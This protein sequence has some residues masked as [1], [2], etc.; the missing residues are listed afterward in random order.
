MLNS[1]RNAGFGNREF[2]VVWLQPLAA[3]LA[4]GWGLAGCGSSSNTEAGAAPVHA[5]MAISVALTTNQPAW[6]WTRTSRVCPTGW[7]WRKRPTP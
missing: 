4:V 5:A 2:S 1:V 7:G 3:A 6:L